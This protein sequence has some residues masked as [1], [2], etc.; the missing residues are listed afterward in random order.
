MTKVQQID[1]VAITVRDI[2]RS[3]AWY[4]DVLG[5]EHRPVAEWGEYPQMVCAGETCV[6]LFP[7]PAEGGT[8]EPPA[9]TVTHFAFRVDRGN[10]ER[11]QEEFRERGIEFEFADHSVA[12][13]VYVH[14]PDG[15]RIE[16]TTYEIQARSV[17]KSRRRP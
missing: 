16:L 9:I 5:L 7:E 1:H 3:I 12:H 14:D 8:G 10:F 17:R 2:E 11:A 13:S 4:T 6:A 15:H